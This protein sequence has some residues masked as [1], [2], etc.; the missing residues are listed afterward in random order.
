MLTCKFIQATKQKNVLFL[1]PE[2]GLL[3]KKRKERK[4]DFEEK[5]HGPLS[6][7]FPRQKVKA[8]ATNYLGK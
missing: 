4:Q 6:Y 8:K 2:H 3:K 5:E 7:F 1:S